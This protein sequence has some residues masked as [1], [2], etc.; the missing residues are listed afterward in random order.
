MQSVFLKK[1]PLICLILIHYSCGYFWPGHFFF[2]QKRT[3]LAKIKFQLFLFLS[4]LLIRKGKKSLQSSLSFP[5]SLPPS[6]PP[7]LVCTSTLTTHACV[8]ALSCSHSYKHMHK[9]SFIFLLT[10]IHTFCTT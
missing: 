1:I 4:R 5:S 3:N 2:L 9:E 10:Q 8:C 7:S 6:P